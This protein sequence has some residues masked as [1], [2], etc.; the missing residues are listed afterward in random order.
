[1][2]II[3]NIDICAWTPTQVPFFN[4]YFYGK[5][6]KKESIHY[7]SQTFSD[8]GTISGKLVFLWLS[9]KDQNPSCLKMTEEDTILS[10]N[11]RLM[12]W[13]ENIFSNYTQLFDLISLKCNLVK[14]QKTIAYFY[15]LQIFFYGELTLP[16]TQSKWPY[17]T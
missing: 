17:K 16:A 12:Q 3:C 13:Q 10:V 2:R 11:C 5:L 14:V 9:K 4:K 15:Q 6:F 8:T 1:M 7:S